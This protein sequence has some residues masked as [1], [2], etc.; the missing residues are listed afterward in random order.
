MV[1]FEFLLCRLSETRREEF[2]IFLFFFVFQ[3]PGMRLKV[4]N[5]ARKS[6]MIDQHKYAW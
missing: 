6:L 2:A 4:F 3:R 5:Q 1:D